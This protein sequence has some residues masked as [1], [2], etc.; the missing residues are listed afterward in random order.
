MNK[1]HVI[2][3][4]LGMVKE[5]GLIN[6]S[7]LELCEK[8]GIPDGSWSH[9]MGCKFSDFVNELKDNGHGATSQTVNKNR[10]NPTLRRDQI[11]TVALEVAKEIGYNK[12]TRINIAERANVSVSLKGFV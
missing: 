10:A 4:A 6:L 1:A 7:R 9:V 11:L 5:S 8:S 2:K 3:I 12:M